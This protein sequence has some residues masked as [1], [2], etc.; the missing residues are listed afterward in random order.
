MKYEYNVYLQQQSYL[1]RRRKKGRY[2]RSHGSFCRKSHMYLG[3]RDL[4]T[5]IVMLAIFHA[6]IHQELYPLLFLISQEP[7]SLLSHF[8]EAS[9]A[10]F[11]SHLG[12]PAHLFRGFSL[13]CQHHHTNIF[14]II[15]SSQSAAVWRKRAW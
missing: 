11:L 12:S 3:F 14:I 2:S 6:M 1:N 10:Y 5:I 7:N 13:L 15:Q 4:L 8:A 9:P